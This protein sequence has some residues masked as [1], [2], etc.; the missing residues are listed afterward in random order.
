MPTI[1]TSRGD[2]WYRDYRKAETTRPPVLFV[3]GA[4]AMHLDWPVQLR[5]MPT[6]NA[7]ALDLP[8]HGNSP[9]TGR[10]SA[11]DYADDVLALLDALDVPQ[12]IIAGHSMGGAI[13]QTL[14]LEAS[15]RVLGLILMA[16]GAVLKV[17][18]VI[19]T[20]IQ[21]NVEAA[22]T[23]II[24]WEW[25]K[26]VNQELKD[27]GRERLLSM[28][29]ET[30]YNDFAACDK[31]NVQGRL[32]DI[33]VPTLVIGGTFDKMTPASLSDEL[34]QKIPDAEQVMFTGAGHMVMLEKPDAIARVV[35]DWLTRRFQGDTK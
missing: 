13:A 25:S 15:E 19:F 33:Q 20:S 22:A 31:F 28:D 8:G 12:A 2:I 11:K 34:E 4:G 21:D 17:N 30:L 18:E 14:A 35:Q 9:G 10:D 24:N 6:A 5:R 1:S 29:P 27:I 7:L 23:M 16:T 32:Q 26:E 3:H